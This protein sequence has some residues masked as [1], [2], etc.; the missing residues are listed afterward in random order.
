MP[1]TGIQ[2]G[3]PSREAIP[4]GTPSREAI[5]L[6]RSKPAHSNAEAAEQFEAFFLKLILAEMR[7]TVGSGGLL[8]GENS[9]YQAILE[10]ALSRRA[11]EAGSFGLAKQIL[12]EM[13]SR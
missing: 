7:R 8:S 13:E 11:A 12:L 3:T 1:H 9:T 5:A 10:D 4:L 6:D 2:I